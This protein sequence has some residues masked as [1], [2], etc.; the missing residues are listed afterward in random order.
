MREIWGYNSGLTSIQFFSAK[1]AA[2]L[3][4]ALARNLEDRVRSRL[5]KYVYPR[6]VTRS[7][8]QMGA[9]DRRSAGL[10]IGN[11]P[12][13]YHRVAKSTAGKS[14]ADRWLFSRG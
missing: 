2:S 14:A 7:P 10:N 11:F 5:A 4:L 1:F 8:Q 6:I 3:D 13:A 12:L 9:L